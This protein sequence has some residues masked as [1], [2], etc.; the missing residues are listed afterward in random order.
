[1][2]THHTFTNG[3]IWNEQF[4]I[5]QYL[6]KTCNKVDLIGQTNSYGRNSLHYAAKGEF[7]EECSNASMSHR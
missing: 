3:S 5:V 7:K 2:V 1:M 6:V 4:E